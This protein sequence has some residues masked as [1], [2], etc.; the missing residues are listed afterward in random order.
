MPLLS[1][2]L[3]QIIARRRH[4]RPKDR[5][6]FLA[7]LKHQLDGITDALPTTETPYV[8]TPFIY[9]YRPTFKSCFCSLEHGSDSILNQR[10][11]KFGTITE[12]PLDNVPHQHPRLTS[13]PPEQLTDWNRHAPVLLDF[14]DFINLHGVEDEFTR[15]IIN[16]YWAQRYTPVLPPEVA[17]RRR[18]QARIPQ[19]EPVP[20][21]IEVPQDVEQV[22]IA[23]AYHRDD[24]TLN[25]TTDNEYQS[26]EINT[27]TSTT[28][29]STNP[30]S[31]DHPSDENTTNTDDSSDVSTPSKRQKRFNHYTP[32][33]CVPCT[34][35]SSFC[36]TGGALLDTAIFGTTLFT[37][38]DTSGRQFPILPEV[39]YHFNDVTVSLRENR[40]GL[41][42]L[43]VC[44]ELIDLSNLQDTTGTG[45]NNNTESRKRTFYAT[46]DART[47]NIRARHPGDT[48]S[49]D[50][51]TSTPE[52][53]DQYPDYSDYITV[54]GE[55]N[56]EPNSTLSTAN[57]LLNLA[58]SD[59]YD[60]TQSD[61]EYDHDSEAGD[62]IL[63]YSTYPR[64]DSD[65]TIV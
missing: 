65:T 48:N 47:N 43:A 13:F 12:Y 41:N 23:H 1:R 45:D 2:R 35:N 25:E 51:S 60:L 56:T 32:G 15:E 28:V 31:G 50:S 33:P 26:N 5:A 52:A 27:N 64:D 37:H 63:L 4:A 10:T 40:T 54:N 6:R 57:A 7:D 30:N 36:H 9:D 17:E 21:E 20:E 14:V 39:D 58:V 62:C 11:V 46:K 53:S 59:T 29:A 3:D 18:L 34:L 22:D 38:L 61:T 49:S 19:E 55:T 44:P 24:S 8:R 16:E 42:I